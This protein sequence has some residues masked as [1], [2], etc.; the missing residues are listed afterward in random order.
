MAA[1]GSSKASS[2]LSTESNATNPANLSSILS[3]VLKPAHKVVISRNPLSE[4]NQPQVSE[5]SMES[6]LLQVK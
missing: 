3:Q 4:G 6:G 2:D 5:T 1:S